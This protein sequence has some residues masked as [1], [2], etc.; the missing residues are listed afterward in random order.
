MLLKYIAILLV[1][2]IKLKSSSD[3]YIY[4]YINATLGMTNPVHTMVQDTADQNSHFVTFFLMAT[5]TKK[6]KLFW[7]TCPRFPPV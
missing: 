7:Q 5:H 4:I 3:I 6:N 2:I 1:G